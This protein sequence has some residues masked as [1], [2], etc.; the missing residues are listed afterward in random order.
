[1]IDI[2]VLDPTITVT[3]S[4]NRAYNIPVYHLRGTI[5]KCTL[6]YTGILLHTGDLDS[7]LNYMARSLVTHKFL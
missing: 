1:M 2:I 3:M 5:N 4:S 6:Y 7:I